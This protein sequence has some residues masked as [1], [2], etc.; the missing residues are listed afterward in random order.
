M[1]SKR[2][3]LDDDPTAIATRPRHF[4]WSDTPSTARD[5]EQFAKRLTAQ[6]RG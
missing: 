2:T 6:K 4:R 5:A 1:S 3:H